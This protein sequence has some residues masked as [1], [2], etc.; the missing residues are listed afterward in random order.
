M[1]LFNIFS[2]IF[3][4]D[5]SKSQFLEVIFFDVGQGDAILIE[6]PQNQQILID[7]GPGT[8]ILEKL[9]KEIPFFDNTINLSMVSVLPKRV[10][11]G[12]KNIIHFTIILKC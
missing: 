1:L 2:W 3:V 5:L 9:A 7:G 11:G 12:I 10:G 6:T 4:F 8:E